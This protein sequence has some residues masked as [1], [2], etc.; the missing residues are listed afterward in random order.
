MRFHNEPNSEP[1]DIVIG[2][3]SV[4]ADANDV[5][6]GSGVIAAD[7]ATAIDLRIVDVQVLTFRYRSRLG[8]DDEGHA[9]P[10]SEH[11]KQQTVTRVRTS[12]GMDGYCFGG[13]VETAALTNRLIGGLNPLDRETVW[14]R[15]LRAQR[16]KRQ[17][18]DDRNLAAIDCALWDFAGRLTGLP[19]SKLLGGARNRVP[20]YA[21]TMCGDDV[22]GG[23]DTPEA[24]GEFALACKERG[25]TAFKLHTWMPPY[26]ADVKRDVAACRAVRER[27]G[28]EM[29]LMLDAHHDYSR[30]EALYLGRALEE[31]DFYW[32]EEPMN[33]H[34]TSSYVWL[35]ERLSI[36]IVGPETAE[37]QMYTRAE[38]I[39]RG[40]SDISRVGVAGI[41]GITPAMKVVHLCQAFGMRVELH[42]GGAANLQVLGAMATPGEYYERGPLHPHFELERE[43][44]WLVEPVDPLAADGTVPVPQAPGLGERIDWD[45]IR[46]QTVADWQG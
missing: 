37:G 28:P 34:S 11:E 26:G 1:P 15:L 7:T 43:T 31:L 3:G 8:Y 45:F 40:A 10:A 22:P 23:L 32:L 14:Y 27:V 39:V 24:Y 29:R 30:E 9:H 20:A 36:P 21:S 33:E 38:W 41:G 12:A 16:L 46:S 18:L 5:P 4:A 25:Y 44:P 42:G 2:E 17:T 19:I 13:S 6:I 35:K